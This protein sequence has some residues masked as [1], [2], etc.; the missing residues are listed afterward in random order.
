MF[1]DI[2]TTESAPHDKKAKIVWDADTLLFCVEIV[3]LRNILA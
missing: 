3:A 1:S 2:K